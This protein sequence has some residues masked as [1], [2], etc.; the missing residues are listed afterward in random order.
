MLPDAR[1]ETSRGALSR[2]LGICRSSCTGTRDEDGLFA[3]RGKVDRGRRGISEELTISGLP[4]GLFIF[5]SVSFDHGGL[6]PEKGQEVKPRER[7][8]KRNVNN[9]STIHLTLYIRCDTSYN[10]DRNNVFDT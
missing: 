5:R 4:A 9:I 3:G 8:Y 1:M 2:D 6:F 10:P 7:F